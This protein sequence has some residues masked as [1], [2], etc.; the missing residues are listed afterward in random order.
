MWGGDHYVYVT[1]HEE[2]VLWNLQA[3]AQGQIV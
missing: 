1:Y 2:N 3:L